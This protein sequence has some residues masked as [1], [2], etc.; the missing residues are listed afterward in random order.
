V[1]GV[2]MN[3]HGNNFAIFS[4]MVF[5]RS[6]GLSMIRLNIK[7]CETGVQVINFPAISHRKID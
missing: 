5:D 6:A 7:H 4:V 3:P 2:H 1:T